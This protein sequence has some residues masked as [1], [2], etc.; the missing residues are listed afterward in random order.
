MNIVER[1]R[2]E[3]LNILPKRVVICRHILDRCSVYT[4]LLLW[5]FGIN[6]HNKRRDECTP[7]FSC[8]MKKCHTPFNKRLKETINFIT[9]HH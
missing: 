5:T 1:Y 7:D 8:C 2:R 6:I 4:Q 9:G 3:Y